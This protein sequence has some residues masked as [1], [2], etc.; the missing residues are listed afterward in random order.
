MTIL[1]RIDETLDYFRKEFPPNACPDIWSDALC[2]H[3]GGITPN[4]LMVF[5]RLKETL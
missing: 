4:D 2:V 1:E 5:V 3:S